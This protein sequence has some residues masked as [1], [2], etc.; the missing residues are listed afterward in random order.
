MSAKPA[1]N[2]AISPWCATAPALSAT[3]AVARRGAAE[4]NAMADQQAGTSN[5]L[6]SFGELSRP[7]T[8]L[9]EKVSEAIGGIFRP[10][11]T[12]RMAKAEAEAGLIKAESDIQIEELKRRA[13]NRFLEEETAKQRNIEAITSSALPM[14]SESARPDEINNDW[15]VNFFDKSRIFSDKQMQYLWASILAGEAN[16]PQSFSRQTVNLGASLDKIDAEV[17]QQIGSISW[18]FDKRTPVMADCFADIYVK[19][20]LDF[21]AL[22]HLDTL[23]LIRFDSLQGFQLRSENDTLEASYFSK[24]ITLTG[25]KMQ[26]VPGPSNQTF[27]PIGQVVLTRAGTE[28]LSVCQ[29]KEIPEFFEY[30]SQFWTKTGVLKTEDQI[31]SPPSSK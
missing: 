4:G 13:L 17:F 18:M 28:L 5:A 24:K 10:F 25:A 7:A 2:P 21:A 11:Q 22:H 14:L 26:H 9:V 20:G 30:C 27:A 31:R 29:S 1:L 6:I 15:I 3:P 23:G 12:K 19:N 16:K 8:V